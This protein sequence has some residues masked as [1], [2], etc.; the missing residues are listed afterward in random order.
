MPF[1]LTH[2]KLVNERIYVVPIHGYGWY[3]INENP[4]AASGEEIKP[5]LP[6]RLKLKEFFFVASTPTA[7]CG[8]IIEEQHPAHSWWV[9]LIPAADDEHADLTRNVIHCFTLLCPQK[10]VFDP[11]YDPLNKGAA[12]QSTSKPRCRGFSM[13]CHSFE[14]ISDEFKKLAKPPPWML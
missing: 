4:P 11:G 9:A 12:V 13:V 1:D 8:L 14:L 5:P 3:Q 7:A 10:P 6:F 2:N